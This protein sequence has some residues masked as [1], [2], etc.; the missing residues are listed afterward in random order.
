MYKRN[1]DGSKGPLIGRQQA[2]I[3]VKRVLTKLGCPPPL[4]DRPGSQDGQLPKVTG[5]VRPS[6]GRSSFGCL[7]PTWPG[8]NWRAAKWTLLEFRRRHGQPIAEAVS[9]NFFCSLEIDDKSGFSIA[10]QARLPSAEP[11]RIERELSFVLLHAFHK[12]DSRPT[13]C[14]NSRWRKSL[15]GSEN[16]SNPTFPATN[17]NFHFWR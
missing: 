17:R 3:R 1:W 14:R 15:G 11:K 10:G 7:S 16:R 4:A 2:P 5:P 13:S 6:L 8:R 12:S 9:P